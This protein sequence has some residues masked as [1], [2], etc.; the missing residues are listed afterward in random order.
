MFNK[1]IDEVTKIP[2]KDFELWTILKYTDFYFEMYMPY[3]C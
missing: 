2:M 3:Y 1:M